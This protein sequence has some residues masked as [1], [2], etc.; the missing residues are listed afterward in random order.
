MPKSRRLPVLCSLLLVLLVVA[1]VL[2]RGYMRPTKPPPSGP[3]YYTGV[4]LNKTGTAYAT[5][6]GRVVPPPPGAPPLRASGGGP[7]GMGGGDD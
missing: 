1:A 7:P 4:M 2:W 6:D 5:E 3:G